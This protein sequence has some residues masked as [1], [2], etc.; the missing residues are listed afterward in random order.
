MLVSSPQYFSMIFLL[1]GLARSYHK[2][3]NNNESTKSWI[4]AFSKGGA[5]SV[6]SIILMSLL[7]PVIWIM[8]IVI[9]ITIMIYNK[10]NKKIDWR[11]L[12]KFIQE[13]I[14][15]KYNQKFS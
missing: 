10:Q 1:V 3:K 12:I 7:G 5:I 15:T 14:K 11:Y 4:L 9:I 8:L 6:V 2:I 13:Q